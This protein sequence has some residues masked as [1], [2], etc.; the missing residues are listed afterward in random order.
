DLL[1]W[2]AQRTDRNPADLSNE[3]GLS[4]ESLFD[5]L[6]EEYGRVSIEKIDPRYISHFL[7]GRTKTKQTK[8]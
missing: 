1:L 8:E 7:L 3:I 5:E 2:L 6:Q 4:L